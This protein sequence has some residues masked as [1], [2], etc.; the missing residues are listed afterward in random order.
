MILVSNNGFQS[1]GN[2][3]FIPKAE[4]TW[5]ISKV[6]MFILTP[7]LLGRKFLGFPLCLF[8]ETL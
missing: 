2:N 6:V 7:D 8:P 5:S 1:G 3:F 4:Q